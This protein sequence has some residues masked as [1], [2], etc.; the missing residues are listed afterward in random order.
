MWFGS[1]PFLEPDD[2]FDDEAAELVRQVSADGYLEIAPAAPIEP[3]R[4]T[5]E[6]PRRWSCPPWERHITPIRFQSTLNQ[7]IAHY[8]PRRWSGID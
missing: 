6:A 7:Q 3:E 4:S 8:S 2:G 1:L 5:S